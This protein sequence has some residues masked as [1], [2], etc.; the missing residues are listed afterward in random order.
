MA[1]DLLSGEVLDDEDA[2]LLRRALQHRRSELHV[3][4][5]AN[6]GAA[7]R[8]GER[9]PGGLHFHAEGA[10]PDYPR[11]EAPEMRR[12]DAGILQDR[13]DTRRQTR[14]PALSAASHLQA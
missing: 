14:R 3:L 4:P 10:P 9:D 12:A 6:A 5:H 11:L 13:H 1:R 8:M 7:R 2:G